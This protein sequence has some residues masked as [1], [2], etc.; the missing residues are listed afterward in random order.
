[1]LTQFESLDYLSRTLSRSEAALAH[2]LTTAL[3]GLLE[4]ASAG[5]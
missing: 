2:T 5:G 3:R 4:G 1:V